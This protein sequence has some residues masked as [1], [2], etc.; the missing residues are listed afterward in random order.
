MVDRLGCWRPPDQR[1]R[2]FQE[3]NRPDEDHWVVKFLV[4]SLRGGVGLHI[5]Q[6]KRL[7]AASIAWVGKI[8]GC[9]EKQ[10]D[11]SESQE[12]EAPTEEVRGR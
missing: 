11:K 7:A 3:G 8:N 5:P 6:R 9:R 12:R 10:R 2:L 1:F 4:C